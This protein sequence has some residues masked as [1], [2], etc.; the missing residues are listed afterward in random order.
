MFREDDVGAGG[1]DVSCSVVVEAEGVVAQLVGDHQESVGCHQLDPGVD[2]S[3]QLG[4]P[5][6]VADLGEGE[7]TL[8]SKPCLLPAPAQHLQAQLPHSDVVHLSLNSN[9]LVCLS[10]TSPASLHSN[11]LLG[12]FVDLFKSG[13]N[14]GL[15]LSDVLSVFVMSW[16]HLE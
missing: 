7:A 3:L 14:P 5:V 4:L 1:G 10:S 15:S 6:G 8:Q 2:C 11:Y 12:I 16:S 9:L 13:L